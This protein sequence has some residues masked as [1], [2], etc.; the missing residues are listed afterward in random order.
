MLFA[1]IVAGLLVNAAMMAYNSGRKA[2][3][4]VAEAAI[5]KLV[6]DQ[7]KELRAWALAKFVHQESV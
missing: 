5:H 3:L 6:R 4:D 1:L 7:D 2:G